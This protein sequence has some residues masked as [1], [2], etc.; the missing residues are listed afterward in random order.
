MV[1]QVCQGLVYHKLSL[2]FTA[3]LIGSA[4]GGGWAYKR[5]NKA[6]QILISLDILL[7][8]ISLFAAAIIHYFGGILS[9]LSGSLL[10]AALLAGTGAYSCNCEY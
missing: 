7:A 6:R 8:I 9:T 10:L 4:A 5:K 3:F 1:F 2:I